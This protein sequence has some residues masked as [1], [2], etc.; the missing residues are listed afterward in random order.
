MRP[1][2]PLVPILHHG[3]IHHHGPAHRPGTGV[4]AAGATGPTSRL[5]GALSLVGGSA[6]LVLVFLTALLLRWSAWSPQTFAAVVDRL[7]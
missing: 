2:V 7:G 5:R 6:L 4:A 3:P 1:A